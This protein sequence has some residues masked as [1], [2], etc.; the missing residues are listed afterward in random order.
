MTASL[1]GVNL[2]VTHRRPVS[3]F[4]TRSL[5]VSHKYL[6]SMC[7]VFP[8]L[9]WD[10]IAFGRVGSAHLDIVRMFLF[11]SASVPANVKSS[12]YT[13]TLTSVTEC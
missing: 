4:L 6:N 9:F 3:L 5:A 7:F 1:D 10:A 8:M 11:S 13:T 2:V 12:P